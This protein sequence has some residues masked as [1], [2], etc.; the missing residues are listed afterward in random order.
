[1]NLIQLS[2]QLKE[3]PDNYLAQEIQK[4]TGN[5]PAYLIISELSR[6]KRMRD[7][8]AKPEP[9]TTVAEDLAGQGG[10]A[11]TPQAMESTAGMDIMGAEE[12]P[13]EMPQMAGGGLVAFQQGK[14]V[15]QPLAAE[16]DIRQAGY[17]MNFPGTQQSQSLY[18]YSPEMRGIIGRIAGNEFAPLTLEQ[19]EE[20]R[21]AGE[22]RFAERMPF[23]REEE[24]RRIAARER[25]LEGER[26]SNVNMA[27][28]EAGLGMMA[29]RS[30][31]GI[32]GVAEGGLKGLS[33]LRAGKQEIKKSE[34]Y[35]D[36]AKDRYARAQE[37]YDEKKY[38]AG[39]REVGRADQ[40][41]MQ[42]L[43]AAESQIR[44]MGMGRTLA[45]ED[46]YSTMEL[47]KAERDLQFARDT[48]K[49]RVAEAELLPKSR[50]AQ[51]ARD[52]AAANLA[53][54]E[55]A[56]GGRAGRGQPKPLLGPGMKGAMEGANEL[57]MM[58][59]SAGS[60]IILPDGTPLAGDIPQ[61]KAIIAGLVNRGLVGSFSTDPQN[62][63]IYINPFGYGA[64]PMTLA[65]RVPGASRTRPDYS[66]NQFTG[67]EQT[68]P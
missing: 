4:P 55:A 45:K 57:V 7:G 26:A 63:R 8:V 54:V 10:L 31:R 42:G 46:L 40:R 3:V 22:K 28:M 24:S 5:Y 15:R 2:E 29:S 65:P 25:A 60:E 16:D 27:L 58:A 64:T 11:D 50:E 21:L 37:L 43:A 18:G 38:A 32:Q 20:R 56:L 13:E 44:A 35:L 62:K 49:A 14:L 51:I 66:F 48:F 17:Q 19:E 12:E 59:R 53:N 36:D 9:Q 67:S 33:A 6:R 34:A 23:R 39:D 41:R 1:M 68:V 52:N 30:P 61:Q 47:E